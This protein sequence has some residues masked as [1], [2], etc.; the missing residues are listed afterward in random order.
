MLP[1]LCCMLVTVSL[2][3]DVSF[4]SLFIVSNQHASQAGRINSQ[5]KKKKKRVNGSGLAQLYA[6]HYGILS[7]AQPCLVIVGRYALHLFFG[8][9]YFVPFPIVPIS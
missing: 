6:L 7:L 4:E 3:R 8:T 1:F 2:C 5:K 9:L